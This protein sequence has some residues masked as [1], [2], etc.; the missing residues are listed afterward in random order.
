MK[1]R[2]SGSRTI[3]RRL[4]IAAVPVA[5]AAAFIVTTVGPAQAMQPRPD[6]PGWQ[7]SAKYYL[8]EYKSLSYEADQA[9]AAGNITEGLID[10]E[11][12][13]IALEEGNYYMS[14]LTRC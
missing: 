8:D 2:I 5:A 14:L 4:A 12:E 11:A 6:C 10:E 3:A 9:Y 1:A 7:A 13:S